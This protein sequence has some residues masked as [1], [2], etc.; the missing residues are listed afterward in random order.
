MGD[1]KRVRQVLINLLGNAVKFTQAGAVSV[2]AYTC[3]A[4]CVR[5]EVVDTGPGVPE[6]QQTLI[7]ERFAQADMSATRQHGGA[8][9]GLA[10]ASD[11]VRHAGG[12]I[13]VRSQPGEGSTFWFT[14]PL[15]DGVSTR[16][17]PEA[18]APAG[19][20]GAGGRVLVAEDNSVNAELVEEFLRA[21]GY[22]PELVSDGE[23][24][25]ARLCERPYTAVLL[26]LHMPGRTGEDVIR[27]VRSQAG[28]NRTAPLFILTAD[29]SKGLVDR[30]AEAGADRCFSKPLNLAELGLALGESG[31]A[32]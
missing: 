4:P 7:F 20:P 21:C 32:A 13:G 5:F 8:G 22:E 9:M 14:W 16:A 18:P 17:V 31:A 26:D 28:P 10:I 25:L 24:A 3:M 27:T 6:D 30:L 15:L 23:A 19:A 29:A 11:L 2:R 1:D 12:E